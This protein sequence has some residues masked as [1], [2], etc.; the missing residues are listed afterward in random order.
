MS[1]GRV[2]QL[3][4]FETLVQAVRG[5]D[6]PDVQLIVVGGA[7]SD[8]GERLFA[9]SDER[10]RFIGRIE[11]S[12]ISALY[13]DCSVYVNSSRQE[14]LSNAVLEAL[15]YSC[16]LVVSDIPANAEMGLPAANYFAVGDVEGLR[17]KIHAALATPDAFR[18]PTEQFAQWSDVCERTLE[19]YR[20]I[21]PDQRIRTVDG[22]DVAETN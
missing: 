22:R 11:R 4:D 3:K 13:Q 19:I 17:A 6:E 2:T 16:P 21:M 5:L 9:Q 1:V 20:D 10:I 7:E 15:S 12:L 18:C 14:G 8:Y